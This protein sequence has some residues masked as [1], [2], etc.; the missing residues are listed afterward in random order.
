M[1]MG[2]CANY[3]F[4]IKGCT[5]IVSLTLETTTLLKIGQCP[6]AQYCQELSLKMKIYCCQAMSR[7]HNLL[8]FGGH[9][10]QD[11]LMELTRLPIQADGLEIALF[12]HTDELTVTT[13]YYNFNSF[14]SDSAHLTFVIAHVLE[15]QGMCDRA[16][17]RGS[18]H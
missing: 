3:M 13:L 2:N 1:I 5:T 17:S 12:S 8:Y 7:G 10:G 16:I 9:Y 11:K 6:S 18:H 4:S 15:V 14:G